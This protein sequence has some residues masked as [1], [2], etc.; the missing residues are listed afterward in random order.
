ME[1]IKAFFSC[2]CYIDRMHP[3]TRSRQ[4]GTAVPQ[5]K[6][7]LWRYVIFRVDSQKYALPLEQVVR[8]LRMVA[9]TPVPEMP[10]WVLG[11]IN[12]AGTAV[13][14][15]EPAHIF[16][17]KS[18]EPEVDDRLLIL[19]A[20]GQTAAIVVDEVLDVFACEP[21]QIESPPPV[22]SNIGVLSATIRR[23]NALIMVLDA[24]CFL[25]E[26]I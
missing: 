23:D 3:V 4:D 14:V 12:I 15:I 21:E 24:Y 5:G 7:K 25:P 1:D 10:D 2:L 6:D 13:P 22:L 8:A 19:K 9:L 16:C 18:K 26:K 17:R 20:G 11:V